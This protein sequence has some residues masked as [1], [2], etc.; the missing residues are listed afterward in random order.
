MPTHTSG[1][2]QA[3]LFDLDGTLVDTEPYWIE[4]EYKL[5]AEFGGQWSDEQAHALV[6]NDLLVSGAVLRDLGG[7]ALD[8]PIIVD[9]MLDDVIA[10][11]REH[12]P[13]RPGRANSSPPAAP[14]ACRVRW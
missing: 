9:R 8:P 2:L 6:G 4:A 3:V 14:P 10:A 1:G 11:T 13:W 7:V 12:I 5:V